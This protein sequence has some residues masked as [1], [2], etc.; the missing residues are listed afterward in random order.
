V[1]SIRNFAEHHS[2]FP[3]KVLADL[4]VREVLAVKVAEVRAEELR[5]EEPRVEMGQ[6]FHP[7]KTKGS[8]N[9]KSLPDFREAF[10]LSG[11]IDQVI[12]W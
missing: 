8:V 12:P 11:T 9:D 6:L 10:L 2:S 4:E 1:A 7:S 3:C 5:V